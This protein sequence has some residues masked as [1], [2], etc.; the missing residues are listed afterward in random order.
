MSTAHTP[1]SEPRREPPTLEEL[2]L[3]LAQYVVDAQRAELQQH[4]G[5]LLNAETEETRRRHEH[6]DS[7]HWA[8]RHEGC[9]KDFKEVRTTPSSRHPRLRGSL[10]EAEAP[11]VT[12]CVR[13]SRRRR[14]G[15]GAPRRQRGHA[16]DGQ[17][18]GCQSSGPRPRRQ[19]AHPRPAGGGARPGAVPAVAWQSRTRPSCTPVPDDET[20]ASPPTPPSPKRTPDALVLPA[21]IDLAR[22]HPRGRRARR[23]GGRQ[24]DGAYVRCAC[25]RLEGVQRRSGDAREGV[26]TGRAGGS[27][28]AAER[29]ARGQARQAR[30][31]HGA[32]SAEPV[33][34]REH[35]ARV[36]RV[37]ARTARA[38]VSRPR[39][40][41]RA[42]SWR[43][44]RAPAAPPPPPPPPR[45][46]AGPPPTVVGVPYTCTGPVD[47]LRVV[48]TGGGHRARE[49]RGGLH[50]HDQ[51]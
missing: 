44:G 12:G 33:Q 8:I 21:R 29:L 1:D 42:P 5:Q 6:E 26:A 7:P 36:A 23:G 47:N 14:S 46:S 50:G 41:L 16:A 11:Q 13:R 38:P 40:A 15:G 10:V 24:S 25:G 45:R 17:R 22:H 51:P 2:R 30:A 37:T 28:S 39:R 20:A 31:W 48:G 43:A 3:K 4:I 34:S 49:P 9:A 18:L 32:G 19:R 27:L 35:A